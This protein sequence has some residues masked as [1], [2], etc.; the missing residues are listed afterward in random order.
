[1][2]TVTV[3][4]LVYRPHTHEP[5]STR[6]TVSAPSIQQEQCARRRTCEQS[7]HCLESLS[8]IHTCR[9]ARPFEGSV[10]RMNPVAPKYFTHNCK[11]DSE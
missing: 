6:C 4:W 2:P 1:V 9:A 5:E 10:C 11:Y 3:V 7:L 8:G